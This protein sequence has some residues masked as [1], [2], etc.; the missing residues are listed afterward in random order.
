MKFKLDAPHF[1][2]DMLLEAGTE[3]GDGTGIPFRFERDSNTV[4]P[5]G[6]R[7]IVK[8]GD[9]MLPSIAMTPLDAE[10]EKAY[11]ERFG[12]VPPAVDPVDR[13][14]IMGNVKDS[15]TTQPSMNAIAG[16]KG[17]TLNPNSPNKPS[18]QADAKTGPVPGAA[19]NKVA[20][21]KGPTAHSEKTPASPA[22]SGPGAGEDKK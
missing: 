6:K 7:V 20:E 10:G 1:I 12:E 18:A 4:R 8:K 14:P 17:P 16:A 3:V 5:D 22:P 19:D 21:S 2:N 15:S 13:I 9:R 11:R